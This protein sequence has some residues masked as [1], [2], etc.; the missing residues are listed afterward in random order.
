MTSA[1]ATDNAENG[2]HRDS[3]HVGRLA[4][5]VP[6]LRRSS[7]RRAPL[8]GHCLF[9]AVAHGGRN[10]GSTTPVAMLRS[11]LQTW[12]QNTAKAKLRNAAIRAAQAQ[13]DSPGS[14]AGR[15]AKAVPLRL[16][17]RVGDRVGLLR[18]HAARHVDGP[19]R[20][21]YHPRGRGSAAA[22]SLMIL[23]GPGQHNARRA[24]EIL[25]DG[26]RP[27]RVVSAGFAGGLS[28]ALQRNDILIADRLL[29]PE[30]GEL[31]R[32]SAQDRRR[33]YSNAA[34]RASRRTA[35]GRSGNAHGQRS[36]IALPTHR[37]PGRRY[38]DVRRGRG[39]R[40]PA[41][42]LLGDPGRQRHGRRSAAARRGAPLGPEDDRGADWGRPSAPS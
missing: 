1:S 17:F 32:R 23:A 41:G 40:R 37:R 7:V 13:L 16:R 14:A 31:S 35:D 27:G 33:G 42:G 38:G 11:L 2:L 8:L 3:R 29:S 25:I 10:G 36:A 19:R 20:R 5:G 9:Q 21:L 39:L 6:L 18:G 28:P 12:L 34:G 15:R 4:D 30:G 22:A 24:T 26:H